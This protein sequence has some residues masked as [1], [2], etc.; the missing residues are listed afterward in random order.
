MRDVNLWAYHADF[1]TLCRSA[2]L[3]DGSGLSYPRGNRQGQ[4]GWHVTV[5]FTSLADLAT[6]LHDLPM[7]AEFCGN[8]FQ[9][10]DPLR[11]G[12]ILRLAILAHGDQ[13][14]QLAVEGRASSVRLT[15]D[16]VREHR[17]DLHAIGLFT[18]RSG[19]TI[20]LMGCLA[21]QGPEGTRLLRQL[22]R[23]WPGRRVVGF[24]TVGYRH[25]G[26][27]KRRGDACELPGMRD[28]DAPAYAFA[29]DTRR[30]DAMWT[31]FARMP[32]ASESSTHAKVVR[33]GRIERCPDGEVCDPPPPPPPP[34]RS[35][36]ARQRD[37]RGLGR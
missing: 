18:R 35:P 8:W 11:R 10:C 4:A 19:S 15:A 2:E 34:S 24:S 12:E 16:T 21:G 28:T 30:L 13:G 31:D 6:R 32:W 17:A 14:G 3:D 29:A 36:N 23:V 1:A 5:R 26:E 27:M 22:S 20:L 9:D 33:D 37:G 25:P 7:P